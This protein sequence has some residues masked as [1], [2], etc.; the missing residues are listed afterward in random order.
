METNDVR[1]AVESGESIGDG[2]R[3]G[4]RLLQEDN[5]LT[6]IADD[7]LVSVVEPEPQEVLVLNPLPR[8]IFY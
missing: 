8:F 4:Q 6:N 7:G 2:S 5:G 1:L 3:T